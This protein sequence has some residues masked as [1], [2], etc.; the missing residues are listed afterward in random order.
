MNYNYHPHARREIDDAA[1]YYD[2]L[3]LK[4]GDDFLEEIDDCISRILMFP[5]A[6]PKMQAGSVRRCRTHRFPYSLIYDLDEEQVFILAVMHES[7]EPNY[8]VDRL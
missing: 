2:N 3:D 5:L 8:W 7:R 4:L 6:W 1:D